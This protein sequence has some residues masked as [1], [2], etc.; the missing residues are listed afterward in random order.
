VGALDVPLLDTAAAFASPPPEAL[1]AAQATIADSEHLVIVYPLWLGTLPAKLKA[2]LEQ[3]GRNGFLLDI[4]GDSNAWAVKK[5]KGRSARLIVTI[6]MPGVA[7][8]LFFGAHSL[9]GLEAGVFR[10]AGFK[11]V[12]RSVFGGVET[13]PKWRT[14]LLN[15]AEALGRAAC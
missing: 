8:R 9:K 11:P 10:M 1:Q 12:R 4:G 6:G 13:G 14:A 5:M 15:K 7:Y 3:I 2:F